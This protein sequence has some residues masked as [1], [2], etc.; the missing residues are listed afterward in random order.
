MRRYVDS[1][2]GEGSHQGAPNHSQYI[3]PVLQKNVHK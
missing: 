3:F 1:R 2:T